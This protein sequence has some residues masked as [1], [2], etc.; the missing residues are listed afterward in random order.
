MASAYGMMKMYDDMRREAATVVELLQG[1]YPLVRKM[2]DAWMAYFEGDRQAVRR[3]LPELEAHL[4]ETGASAYSIA[5]F[6]FFL[7]ENDK[8]Y[9]WLE[10]AYSRKEDSLLGIKW[11]W[12]FDGV[13]TDPRYF[14]LLKRLG[15]D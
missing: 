4:Q 10:R 8:G 1:T 11:D 6:D 7:C 12:D 13:R 5:C 15:L 2:I 14:D 9:E 3:L